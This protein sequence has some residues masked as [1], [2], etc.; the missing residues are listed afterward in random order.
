[1]EMKLAIIA[2][3]RR[4]SVSLVPG[5]EVDF[6]GLLLSA[7]KP[8]LRVRLG[9]PEAAPRTSEVRGGIRRVLDL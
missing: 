8:G 9:P 6:G 4:F 1:M 3:L 2:I 7:P 5:T